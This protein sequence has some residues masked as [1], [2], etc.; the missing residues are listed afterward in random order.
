MRARLLQQLN[1]ILQT[2]DTPKGLIVTMADV[3][4]ESGSAKLRPAT[5]EKLAKVSGI[6]AAY[7]GLNLTIEGHT[8]SVGGD[9]YNQQLSEKRAATVRDYL[10][11][12]GVSLNSV[13]ALGFGKREPVASNQ[14]SMGR[15]LNRR[16]ELIVSGDAIGVSLSSAVVK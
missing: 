9:E 4:F 3:L 16:V 6:I 5:R 2:R 7:P 14:T 12:Q 1:A 15:Q 11:Q 13:A 8:D 10:I